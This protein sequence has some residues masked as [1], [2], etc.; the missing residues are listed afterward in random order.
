ML[1]SDSGRQS[2]WVNHGEVEELAPQLG[3]WNQCLCLPITQKLVLHDFL[4]GSGTS[5]LRE[6]AKKHKALQIILLG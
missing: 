5:S 2:A 1:G 3:K 4:D 6:E